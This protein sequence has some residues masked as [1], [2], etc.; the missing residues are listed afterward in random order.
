MGLTDSTWTLAAICCAF[1]AGMMD[2]LVDP[3]TAEEVRDQ[4]RQLPAQLVEALL[5]VLT[6][7]GRVNRSGV[8][9]RISETGRRLA[10][11]PFRAVVIAEM[12]S[13]LLQPRCLLVEGRR[14]QRSFVPWQHTDPDVLEAQGAG[15]TLLAELISASLVASLPG[16]GAALRAPG[17]AFLDVGA[18]VG[19]LSIA[20]AE[21]WPSLRVVG[22]EPWRPAA[23]LARRNVAEATL[24]QRIEIRTQRVEALSDQGIFDLAWLPTPF[25]AED[26]L[27]EAVSRTQAGLRVGGWLVAGITGDADDERAQALSRLVIATCGGSALAVEEGLSLL[28]D[29]GL[30]HAEAV[31]LPDGPTVLIARKVEVTAALTTHAKQAQLSTPSR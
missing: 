6:A 4:T 12:K 5:G 28:V 3:H 22:L 13:A 16:L 10:T 30:D 14:S 8:T 24:T 31:E 20:M 21:R 17:A 23:E 15:G 11:S 7:T 25:I 27:S 9:F 2:F 29:A 26:V 18:G 1:D 19:R